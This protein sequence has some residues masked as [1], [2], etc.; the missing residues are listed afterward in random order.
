MN[1][2]QDKNLKPRET[3]GQ[4]SKAN[5]TRKGHFN[6]YYSST[7]EGLVTLIFNR[8]RDHFT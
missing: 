6:N 4:Q 5:T 2:C 7:L 1:K 3:L 8:F